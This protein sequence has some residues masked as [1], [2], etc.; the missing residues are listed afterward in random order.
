MRA[1]EANIGPAFLS[2]LMLTCSFKGAERAVTGAIA[3]QGQ[4]RLRDEL[5]IATAKC[6]I[7]QDEAEDQVRTRDESAAGAWSTVA[8]LPT[9]SQV[10][11]SANA[12]PVHSRVEFRNPGLAEE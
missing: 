1:A 7:E 12:P 8:A 3:R 6:A 4:T 9:T 5:V 2:A 10:F 11:R